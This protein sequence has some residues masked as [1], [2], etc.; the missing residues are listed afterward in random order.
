M[1]QPVFCVPTPITFDIPRVPIS[2]QQ[3]GT[4]FGEL[5]VELRVPTVTP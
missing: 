2:T 4:Y 3:A 1:S 5:Q